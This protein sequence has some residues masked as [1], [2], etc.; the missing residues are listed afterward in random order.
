MC[1]NNIIVVD[2]VGVGCGGSKKLLI[3]FLIFWIPIFMS[4]FFLL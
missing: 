2:V 1:F 4:I 3:G